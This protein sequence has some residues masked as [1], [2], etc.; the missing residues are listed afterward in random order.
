MAM[1]PAGTSEK[2]SFLHETLII[3]YR[4]LGMQVSQVEKVAQEFPMRHERAI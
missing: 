2:S 1:W 4:R 3:D